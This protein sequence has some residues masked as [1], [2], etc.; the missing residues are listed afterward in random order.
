M[1][2][3]S[4]KRPIYPLFVFQIDR[5]CQ[6]PA[7]RSEEANETLE[8]LNLGHSRRTGCTIF[9]AYTSN[10]ITSGVREILK[11]LV[12]HK[13]VDVLITSAGGIEEDF[14][15]CMAPF[16]IGDFSKWTGA[17]LRSL[18][19]NRTG[20]LLV[21]NT[22]YVSFEDWLIPIFDQLL[23]EQNEQK[24]NW[25]PSKI[26]DR[27][28]KEINNED[29]VYYWCHKVIFYAY[30]NVSSYLLKENGRGP[31]GVRGIGCGYDAYFVL[32][33]APTALVV[34]NCVH[35]FPSTFSPIP[36]AGLFTR[37]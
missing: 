32:D 14:V 12:Q 34:G 9:L 29:S 10:M 3:Y 24:I 2:F 15:K 31:A 17:T 18:G 13:M 4:L 5:K 16:Y 26:I 37:N 19:I 35:P 21:P 22:N 27:L 20:N 28:G 7:D 8:E 33:S 23:K 6:F 1:S 11:F 25:T 36:V 30:S